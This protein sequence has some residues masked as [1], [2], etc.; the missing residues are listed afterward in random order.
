M[1]AEPPSPAPD[2]LAGIAAAAAAPEEAPDL[3]GG[4]EDGGEAYDAVDLPADCPVT[5]LGFMKQKFYFLDFARQLIELGS[6]FR[7]GELMALFGTRMGFL[8]KRWPQ[9][10]KVGDRKTGE[11]GDDGKPI[12]VPVFEE[13]GF[14]QKDAQRGLILACSKR[15][16]FDPRGRVRGRGAHLGE[17]GE[18]VLHCGDSVMV[19]G[20]KGV[21]GRVL[22]STTFRTGLV[23]RYV[24]PTM[25][26][27]SAPAE[28]PATVNVG[29]EILRLL[30]TWNWKR[31]EI[32]P[33]LL[34]CWIAAARIGGA[35]RI[36]PHGWI[37][38][39][40]GAGKTTLQE[41]LQCLMEDWG[42]FTEDATEAGVRQLL[43]QDT[44]A[45][46]FDEIEAEEDNEVVVR[47][48]VRLARLAYSGAS[49]VRGSTDHNAKQFVARSCFLFSSI[50]HHELPAQ[51]RNRIAI[52]NLAPFPSK[53]AKFVMPPVAKDWGAQIA[54]RLIEQWPR[55]AATL[56]AYQREMF[57]QGYT[58]REQ[59]T[60]GTLL[61]AGD[62]LLHESVPGTGDLAEAGSVSRCEELVRKLAPLVDAVR[63]EAVDTS[64]RCVRHLASY[65]LPAKSGESQ[66]TIARWLARAV[67]GMCMKAERNHP[68][69]KLGMH[70][71]RI[72]HLKEN[73]EGTQAGMVEAT[74][75]K[76]DAD[77][78]GY[79]TWVAIAN[80]TNRGMAEIFR[81]TMWSSG[82]WNQSLVLIADAFGNKKARFGGGPSE[83]CVLVPLGEFIDVQ[84]AID[85]ADELRA[86]AAAQPDLPEQRG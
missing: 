77:K 20:R 31:P 53:T 37:T 72:V 24:Y 52:L 41:F 54:R 12:T 69:E 19:G 43:D 42:I 22:K 48:I 6:E 36:R 55:F 16:I 74:L 29:M 82:N 70:G 13:D 25:D 35:L 85:E 59:D 62:L 7:K 40:S 57:N 47:K 39:P 10:K 23:G 65:R 3:R 56:D 58:G 49:S 50:H 21:R 18:L 68:A 27:I 61:A 80:K 38:G 64:A 45:V 51:D 76:G 33:Y 11:N 9:W 30:E 17:D 73:H 8:E 44:L 46:M 32:A 4:E 14:S 28:T 83:G 79:A 63:A 86:M 60:Y 71:I 81:D 67:I 26:R 15:G 1:T 84:A 2:P 66:E 34:L 75:P 78:G 5:A